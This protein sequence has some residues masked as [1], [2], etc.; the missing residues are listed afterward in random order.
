MSLNR[1]SF[2]MNMIIMRRLEGELLE[3]C[4]GETFVVNNPLGTLN[5]QKCFKLI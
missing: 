4:S 3:D 1:V 2:K 5:G